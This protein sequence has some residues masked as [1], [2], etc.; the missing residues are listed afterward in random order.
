MSF[1][2]VTQCSEGLGDEGKSN[3]FRRKKDKKLTEDA[4]NDHTS[5]RSGGAKTE[6]QV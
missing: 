2:D 1:I 3:W 4:K 5:S 6:L